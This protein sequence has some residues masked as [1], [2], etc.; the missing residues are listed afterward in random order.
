MA[1]IDTTP[2][3]QAHA[4]V[5]RFA[6][7]AD[8]L[9]VDVVVVG[10]GITGITAAYQLSREG[11]RVALFERARCV[12]IDTGHTTAHVTCVTD[13][14]LTALIRELGDD[15][16]RAVWD[17]GLAALAEIGDTIHR[18]AIA[19]DFAW[20]PGYLHAPVE[21]RS[22]DLAAAAEELR[23]EAEAAA[24][25]GFD[26][27][28][29]ET[30]P[31]MNRPA[32]EL[33]DQARLHPRKYLA[34]LLARIEGHGAQVFE[35]S[36]VEEIAP[37]PDSTFAVRVNGHTVTC[38]HV[39]IATHNPIVGASS[40]VSASLLQTKLALYTSYVIGGRV[41]RGRVPDALYWDTSEPYHYLRIQPE[42]DHDYVIYGG[43]DHKTGQ[44]DDTHACYARLEA[45]LR[46]LMPG[47]KVTHRWSG[48]VIEANDGLPFIGETA[49]R[50][51]AATGFA[52]NGITFGTL[53]GMMA[54]DAI[55]GRANP[56]RELFDI[57]RTRLR[58]GL[59]NYLT[60]NKD[61][62]YYLV[63]DRFAGAE[64]KSL[65]AVRRGQGKI[66]DLDGQRVAAYRAADGSVSI[67]SA[68]CTHLGCTVE[69]NGAEQTWDCPCHG[70]RFDTSGQVI[71]GPAESPLAEARPQQS[72]RTR[73]R[74]R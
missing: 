23:K 1:E 50:Q 13:R 42:R 9:R 62:P 26:A 66:L 5:A 31:Y 18:E 43:E 27:T 73:T 46:R 33:A 21:S 29:V 40:M 30:A 54:A 8:D 11:R 57:D 53:G 74:G 69:W 32:M 2:Y 38:D 58:G 16:A 71:S 25:L 19:C 22:D 64:G 56:W 20:V 4:Q 45:S 7:L 55:L 60:E 49:E 3:W 36:A 67:R 12:S 63:R 48:Q 10:G 59:W 6:S 35:Q 72:A 52:G 51:F 34:G 47:I 41:D 37:Q 61:Y 44:A 68:T 28:F 15:H 70:S 24:R 14:R 39:V 17:A 65:R